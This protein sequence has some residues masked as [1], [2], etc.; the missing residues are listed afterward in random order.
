MAEFDTGKMYK[1]RQ[2]HDMADEY[3]FDDEG[4]I[5]MP[6]GFLMQ[7]KHLCGEIVI[8]RDYNTTSE[9]YLVDGW[10][11]TKEMLEDIDAKPM[12]KEGE[13]SLLSFMDAFRMA[14]E[15]DMKIKHKDM[16]CSME[17]LELFWEYSKNEIIKMKESDE[18]E[19]F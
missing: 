19:V 9:D 14:I 7:M 15:S 6:G 13:T 10:T 17:W 18:W 16:P 2:W 4:D 3:G 11:I 1:I 12:V 5:N 8:P